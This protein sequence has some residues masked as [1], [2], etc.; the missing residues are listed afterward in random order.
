MR[1]FLRAPFPGVFTAASLTST[2]CAQRSDS[3]G[4]NVEVCLGDVESVV[5]AVAAGASRVELCDS[6]SEG[7]TTP[8][9]GAI[10][11][12]VTIARGSD[13]KIN[14]LIRPRA[15]DFCFTKREVDVMVADIDAARLAGV[16]GVVIGALTPDGSLDLPTLKRLIAAAKS[17]RWTVMGAPEQSKTDRIVPLQPLTVTFHR[18]FDLCADPIATLE[19]LHAL[20]INCSGKSECAID[21]ILTSGQASS[22][23]EGRDTLRLLQTKLHEL[24]GGT[25]RF[26]RLIAG[27]GVNA[28]NAAALVSST[29]IEDIH[30]GSALQNE[31]VSPSRVAR[32]SRNGSGGSGKSV[33]MGH[34]SAERE[35]LIKRT[36]ASKVR[37]LIEVVK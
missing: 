14:V 5:E 11:G 15:G 35:H 21:Y 33:S 19:Q 31:I 16:H 26:M 34:G 36:C 13:T 32:A 24:N 18:A 6:L 2:L 23:W 4:V 37:G 7:G 20:E 3:S 27:A 12:A 8:S 22:A 29:G 17:E 30:A 1:Q 28:D 10:A 25:T 9:L